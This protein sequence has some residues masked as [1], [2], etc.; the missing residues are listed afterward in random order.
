MENEHNH[1]KNNRDNALQGKACAHCSFGRLLIALPHKYGRSRSTARADQSCKGGDYHDQWHTYTN[2]RQGEITD[3]LHMT[4][5]NS[6]NDV[7]KQIDYLRCYSWYSKLKK[8]FA[9]RLA[10]EK[11]IVFYIIHFCLPI[12]SIWQSLSPS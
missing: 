12:I 4:D 3:A 2:T 8:Q 11:A 7:V 5:V 1:G 9:K 6:V 10:T